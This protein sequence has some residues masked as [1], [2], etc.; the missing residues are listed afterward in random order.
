MATIKAIISRLMPDG[1]WAEVGMNHRTIMDGK[2]AESIRRKAAAWAGGPHRIEY[3]ARERI[4]GNPYRVEHNTN[5]DAAS[6]W[7]TG[8]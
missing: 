4:Y 3:F 2:N 7:T 1:S 8:E 5:G 6:Y